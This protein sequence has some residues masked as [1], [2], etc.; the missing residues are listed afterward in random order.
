MPMPP[1]GH[2]GLADGAVLHS[3]LRKQTYRWGV[4]KW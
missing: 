3:M 4:A 2:G 1:K